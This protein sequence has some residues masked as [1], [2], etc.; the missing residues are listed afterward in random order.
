VH[1]LA[2][3]KVSFVAVPPNRGFRPFSGTPIKPSDLAD[4]ACDEEMADLAKA[5][6]RQLAANNDE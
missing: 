6:A 5:L 2:R 1:C 4:A 3:R